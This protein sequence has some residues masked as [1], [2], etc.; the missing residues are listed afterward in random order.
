MAALRREEQTAAAKVVG[1]T[2]LHFLGHPDGRL[3]PTLELRRD[4][5]RVI[6]IVQ[7]HPRA[8]A[9]P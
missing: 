3:Q 1:V 6:R 8:H 4:I 5:S 9:V 7:P 2:E